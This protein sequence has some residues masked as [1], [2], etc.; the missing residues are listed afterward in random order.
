M[1]IDND[2]GMRRLLAGL[3]QLKNTSVDIGPD[4]GQ[5]NTKIQKYAAANEFGAE[6]KNGFGKGVLI[7]IPERSFIRSTFDNEDVINKVVKKFDRFFGMMVDGKSNPVDVMNGI[8]DVMVSEIKS[9][10][11][12]N[13]PPVNSAF[14]IKRKGKGKGTLYDTGSMLKS[15]TRKVVQS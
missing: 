13:V 1:I 9:T 3:E 12:S 2:S 14:T 15:I 6:I 7:I 11:T 4:V 5:E 10:I 8:G